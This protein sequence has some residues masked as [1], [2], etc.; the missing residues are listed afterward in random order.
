LT[1]LGLNSHTTLTGTIAEGAVTGDALIS[2]LVDGTDQEAT[3]E[4]EVGNGAIT[5]SME[6]S[7]NYGGMDLTFNQSFEAE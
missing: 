7:V 3:W 5:G 2:G 6:V 4:G 1:D